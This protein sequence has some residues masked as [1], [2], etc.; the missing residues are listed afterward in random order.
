[1]ID[2]ASWS[3]VQDHSDAAHSS[4]CCLEVHFPSAT[5]GDGPKEEDGGV[6]SDHAE[7]GGDPSDQDEEAWNDQD[8][9]EDPSEEDE[10]PSQE[11][12]E[13]EGL[14]NYQKAAEE[15]E[16]PTPGNFRCCV[17]RHFLFR[18][19]EFA[20]GHCDGD[21]ASCRRDDDGGDGDHASCRRDDDGGDA[22]GYGYGYGYGDDDPP[23]IPGNWCLKK[24]H[25]Q[26]WKADAITEQTEKLSTNCSWLSPSLHA[27]IVASFIV[28]SSQDSV[29]S[30]R[31]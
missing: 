20:L 29:R 23:P 12:E 2:E 7:E 15:E 8:H 6:P 25:G 19:S 26:Q 5:S 9:D 18:L 28:H 10:D 27:V 1:M 22:Y 21:H 3:S 14:D 30:S 16:D 17:H 13:G 31:K 4:S 11:E 24:M